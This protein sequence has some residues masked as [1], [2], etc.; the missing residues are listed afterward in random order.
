MTDDT[1]D[2]PPRATFQSPMAYP[3]RAKAK[4]VKGYVVLSLAMPVGAFIAR[5]VSRETF[6]RVILCLLLLIALRL[7]ITAVI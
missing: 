2:D 7:T 1:V 5:Y 6:D 4:G 3:P